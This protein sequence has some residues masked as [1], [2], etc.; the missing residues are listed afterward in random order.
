MSAPVAPIHAARRSTSRSMSNPEA[1]NYAEIVRLEASLAALRQGRTVL[2][3]AHRRATIAQA[4]RVATQT[5]RRD[6]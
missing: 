5:G 4:D 2:V 6:A 1:K 3:V